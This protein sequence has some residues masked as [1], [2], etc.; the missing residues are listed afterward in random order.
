MRWMNFSIY[1]VLPDAL[2][3]GV[4]SASNRNEY[5]KQTNKSSLTSFLSLISSPVHFIYFSYIFFYLLLRSLLIYFLPSLF[6]F[7]FPCL[8]Y[9]LILSVLNTLTTNHEP[10]RHSERLTRCPPHPAGPV[11][12]AACCKK[13]WRPHHVHRIAS[14]GDTWNRAC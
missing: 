8:L 4:Y 9:L 10:Q 2:G 14:S 7:F 11:L 1:L 13:L 5:Q 3:P 6:V 12:L